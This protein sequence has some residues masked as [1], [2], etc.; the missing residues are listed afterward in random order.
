M[1]YQ[2]NVVLIV[3][4]RY[5]VMEISFIT[6]CD[7]TVESLETLLRIAVSIS[8]FVLIVLKIL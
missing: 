4:T 5:N 7:G 1:C 3:R 6:A 8:L 2:N